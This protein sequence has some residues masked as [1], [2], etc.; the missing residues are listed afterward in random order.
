MRR[1]LSRNL[2]A[3]VGSL[4]ILVVAGSQTLAVQDDDSDQPTRGVVHRLDQVDAKL[5]PSQSGEYEFINASDASLEIIIGSDDRQQVTNTTNF[6]NSAVTY[7]EAF[8]EDEQTAFLCTAAFVGPNV[9]L[10][11]AHCLWIPEFGGFPD[12]V[13]IAPGLN[14][15]DMPFGFDFASEIWVPD[16]WI[17]GNGDI[18]QA[19]GADYGLIVLESDDLSADTG[20]FTVGVM[21]SATLQS[22]EFVPS[23]AGYPGDKPWGTQWFGS[24]DSFVEVMPDL[25]V[26]NIDAFQGQS[27]SPVWQGDDLTVVGVLSFETADNNYARRIT[28]GVMDDLNAACAML[29]CAIN[30][31]GQTPEPTPP[32]EPSPTATSE[33]PTTTAEPTG[34]SEPQPT[35]TAEPT[36]PP[37]QGDT[38]A[39]QRTW[40]RTDD[41]VQKGMVS[42]TWMWGPAFTE[43]MVEPYDESGGYRTV[44]YHEKSRMEI[45]NPGG[46]ATS[47][48]YVTNGLIAKELVKGEMQVG[49][50]RFEERSPANI[51]VAG[52]ANDPNGPVYAS[53]LDLLGAA[54]FDTGATITATVDRAGNV[55][56]DPA[57]AAH[58]VT[59]AHFAP[60]TNHTVAS[61]FWNFMNASGLVYDSGNY[62]EDLLF[63][64]P[65]FAT[66]LPIT[67]P[68]WA[69]VRVGGTE[70]TVLV[71]VF[72]RRVLTYT[73]GNPPGWDVEAGNVGLHYFEW[74]YNSDEPPA[75]PEPPAEP[76]PEPPS[77]EMPDVAVCLD[78]VESE[79]LTLI[80]NYRVE[81]GLAPFASS[82]TLNVAAYDHSLDMSV[83]DYFSHTSQDGAS[84][85]D[86]MA[87]AGYDYNTTKGENIAYGYPSAADVFEGWR[88]SPGH[89]ANM[90]HADF[91][92]IGIGYVS[93]GHYWT[94]TF[95]GHVDAAPAC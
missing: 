45:T 43:I 64:N 42:R 72:E 84:P 3:V 25:L 83:N 89:D 41:P 36:Q 50:S 92:A 49:D 61:V 24:Q 33:P 60:E 85:W 56:N 34:T 57:L 48:W 30:Q 77:G 73:P 7:I 70:R 44:V 75:Q 40:Q 10:T 80:N 18:N 88:N 14:G 12:G 6:P 4:L 69:T 94:T 87:E 16:A 38:N 66:G 81:N 93:D 62:Y 82:A 26:H 22:G 68:Y 37:V 65:Y 2:I 86:R 79:F 11:A 20:E 78:A 63:Q 51:N 90:L 31:T 9:L 19:Y 13:A 27:G 23:T 55:G 35:S 95:G 52:D 47:I 59:A 76:T 71:Q 5:I 58:G 28:S 54:P 1:G 67:E 15:D 21:N 17:A 91:G 8:K 32:G 46:D 53:F 74:R 29:G 39:F